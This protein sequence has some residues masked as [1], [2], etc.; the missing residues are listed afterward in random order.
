MQLLKQWILTVLNLISRSYS[1]TPSTVSALTDVYRLALGLD[2]WRLTIPVLSQPPKLGG[3]RILRAATYLH[4]QLGLLAVGLLTSAFLFPVVVE[5]RFYN[6]CCSVGVIVEPSALWHFQLGP[7]P[8]VQLSYGSWSLKGFFRAKRNVL[9]A[10][11]HV[12]SDLIRC[13]HYFWF[14]SSQESATI[15]YLVSYKVA[16]RLV[17]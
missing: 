13:W 16:F 12:A 17:L 9:V 3:C 7:G 11:E 2:L 4:I 1:P 10:P 15:F 5:K 8:Q 6:N 14:V